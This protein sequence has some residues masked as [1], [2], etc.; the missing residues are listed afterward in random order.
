MYVAR[1][2]L[3]TAENLYRRAIQSYP[4]YV[5]AYTNLSQVAF[6]LGRAGEAAA[7]TEKIHKLKIKRKLYR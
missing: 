6:A 1:G 2:D 5:D 4:D 7:L 3:S